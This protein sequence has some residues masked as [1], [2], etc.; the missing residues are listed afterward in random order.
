MKIDKSKVY[1]ADLYS[2]NSNHEEKL[3]KR[4]VIFIQFGKKYVPLSKV[5]NASL[6]LAVEKEYKNSQSKL[7]KVVN[8]IFLSEKLPTP[9]KQGHI[10][11]N[12]QRL[13]EQKGVVSIDELVI[14]Q[15]EYIDK[16]FFDVFFYN[17]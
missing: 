2:V 16:A 3:E 13:Y 7:I 17:E 14:T 1:K 6:Y 5:S 12:V 10:V 9:C 4:N 11:K 8:P 15:K